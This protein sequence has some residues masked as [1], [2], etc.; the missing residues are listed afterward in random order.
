MNSLKYE[1]K[2]LTDTVNY[3]EFK[4]SFC[5]P[6]VLRIKDELYKIITA[7][8][9]SL[10]IGLNELEYIDSVGIGVIIGLQIRTKE[11]NG[12]LYLICEKGKIYKII[13]LVGLHKSFEIFESYDQAA[14]KILG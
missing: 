10:L 7:K 12:R 14:A 6:D 8:E 9:S 13:E 2:K 1:M 5:Y 3:I 11:L 4:G